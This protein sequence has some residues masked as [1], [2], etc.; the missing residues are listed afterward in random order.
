MTLWIL[1][2]D[3]VSLMLNGDRVIGEKVLRQLSDTVITVI[4][5]QELFNGWV[6]RINDPARADQLILLYTKL[7][8][9]AE[10]LKTIRILNFDAAADTYYKS[11]LNDKSLSQKRLQKDLRIAAIALSVNGIMVTRNHRDFSK[12]PNLRI[13]DWTV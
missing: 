10:F 12:V 4:T 3:H 11:W 2:T 1:D 9:T 8:K 5:V 7:W 6:G 13:E